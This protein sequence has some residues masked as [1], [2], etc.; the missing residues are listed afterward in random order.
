[1]AIIKSIAGLV[2][3][4]GVRGGDSILFYPTFEMGSIDLPI[5]LELRAY[6]RPSKMCTLRSLRDAEGY[7]LSFSSIVALLTNGYDGAAAEGHEEAVKMVE[8]IY[9]CQ[10]WNREAVIANSELPEPNYSDYESLNAAITRLVLVIFTKTGQ[11][12]DKCKTVDVE[13][14]EVCLDKLKRLVEEAEEDC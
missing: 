4:H 11:Y 3:N 10:L 5:K 8:A 1:M 13:G 2:E 6:S 7:N 12:V 14:N 9:G